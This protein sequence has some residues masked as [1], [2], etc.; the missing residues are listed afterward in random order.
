MVTI[1]IDGIE[2][3]AKKG[4]NILWVALDNGLYIPNLCAVR[5]MHPPFAS[6]RLCFVEIEGRS[7]PVT[8]CTE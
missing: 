6:C 3:K 2:V 4:T 8:A 1:I 5:E 7:A